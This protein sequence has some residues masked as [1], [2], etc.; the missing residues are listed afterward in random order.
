MKLV[1]SRLS[2]S[3]NTDSHNERWYTP[4]SLKEHLKK[5]SVMKLTEKYSEFL[6]NSCENV[7]QEIKNLGKGSSINKNKVINYIQNLNSTL[8]SKL[9]EIEIENQVINLANNVYISGEKI[10]TVDDARNIVTSIIRFNDNGDI[11]KAITPELNDFISSINE[12]KSSKRKV[13]K[14]VLKNKSRMKVSID[15]VELSATQVLFRQLKHAAKIREVWGSF[16][17]EKQIPILLKTDFEVLKKHDR[18]IKKLHTREQNQ[19][20][21]SRTLHTK[22]YYSFEYKEVVIAKR[23]RTRPTKS[24]LD[25]SFTPWEICGVT[26][27]YPSPQPEPVEK[28]YLHTIVIKE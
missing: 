21:D 16:F 22:I 28:E 6:N 24:N 17:L 18:I 23:Y 9:K 11:N 13:F 27:L 14:L 7:M 8:I 1:H 3:Y 2:I 26:D 19:E 5:N 10:K 20:R 15:G 25:Y 4:L 12:V